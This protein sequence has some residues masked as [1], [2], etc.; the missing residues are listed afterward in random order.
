ME[1]RRVIEGEEGRGGDDSILFAVLLAAT[2]I[3]PVNSSISHLLSR[4]LSYRILHT[5]AL[6][7]FSLP[8]VLPYKN[9]SSVCRMRIKRRCLFVMIIFFPAMRAFNNSCHSS[10]LVDRYKHT[11]QFT[12]VTPKGRQCSIAHPN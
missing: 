7:L 1:G 6:S 10:L 12:I 11:L 2:P 4:V 8:S 5:Y 9:D 3:Q